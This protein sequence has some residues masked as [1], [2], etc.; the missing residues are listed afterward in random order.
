LGLGMN[1]AVF[2]VVNAV[3]IRSLPYR[4][5]GR[6]ISLWEE[7]TKQGPDQFNS[8]GSKVGGAGGPRRTT[9]S[10]ANLLDYRNSRAF[11]GLAG[12]AFSQKNLTGDGTPERLLGEAVTAN[13]FGLLGL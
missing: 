3:I 12:F 11:I 1:T 9:V 5:P 2:S 7:Y 8:S 6:L 10:V 13:Y 4:E